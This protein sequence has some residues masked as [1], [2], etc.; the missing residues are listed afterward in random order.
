MAAIEVGY[1][2]FDTA[3]FYQSEQALVELSSRRSISSRVM[4]KSSLLPSYGA[5]MPPNL[6]LPALNTTLK[7][8]GLKYV[9]AFSPLGVYGASS[10]A[11]N[12]GIDYYTIIEDLA[13]A[14]GKTLP[15]IHHPAGS[16][17]K[18]RMKQ[19]LEIFD[20]ELGEYEMNKIN[21]IPQRRLYAGDFVYEV[22]PY[23]SLHQLWDG[24]P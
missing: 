19:N 16:F 15:Q 12:T 20:W 14:K 7:K 18:E 21:Q 5:Q 8:L 3:A 17:N 2:H 6:I 22:G 9:S 11:T 4:M 1:H 23:K 10:S 13:A 24:D